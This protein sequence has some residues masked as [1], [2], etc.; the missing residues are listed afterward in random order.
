MN[1]QP[2]SL[3]V[4]YQVSADFVMLAGGGAACAYHIASGAQLGKE[5]FVQFCSKHY[6]DIVLVNNEGATRSM[7]SGAA[8]WNWNDATKRVVRQVVMEPTSTPED[9][10]DADPTLFNRWYVLRH[11]MAV[12]ERTATLAD[13]EIL[14]HHLM[15]ISDGDRE[16]VMYFLNWLAWLWQ[17]PDV[18]IPTAIMLYSRRGRI[19]KSILARLLSH[20]FGKS[21]VKSCDGLVLHKNFMDAI[22]HRRLVVLNELAR[23]DRQDSYERF[24]SL[25]SEETMELECK[26]KAS[27]EIRNI[28][29]YIVTTNNADALPLMENDGRILVLRC[30][31]ERKPNEY[32]AALADWIDG[33]GPELLAGVLDQWKFPAEFDPYAPV[34]QTP[35]NRKTQFESRS[36][37]HLFVQEL[38]EQNRAPFDKDMGRVSGLIE[39][40]NT[41]YPGN[42]KG[43]RLNNKT[44]P[45]V[46][47]DLG[48]EQIP[49]TWEG[50][51]GKPISAGVWCW[52]N[53]D[54]W[55]NAPG[56]Q[57]AAEFD[58]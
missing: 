27:H 38:I 55:R 11:E 36:G 30:E 1:I 22:V 24:K 46:L 16:G 50:K 43:M 57:R 14:V 44:L 8:W 32:Y 23:S 28:A 41:L 2:T 10:E 33:N 51:G 12:P 4:L 39:Q 56:A 35:A 40:L 58:N 13:V 3:P 19:G 53:Q 48:S 20:V 25:I 34:P 26:G 54:K 31:G 5:G 15:Y 37:L 21:L 29:H 52:R 42:L 6:G 18:K 49:T 7:S 47:A 9:S 17:F 45:A